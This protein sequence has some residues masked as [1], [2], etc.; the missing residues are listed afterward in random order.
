MAAGELSVEIIGRHGTIDQTKVETNKKPGAQRRGGG[1]TGCAFGTFILL[2]IALALLSV[3]CPSFL[4]NTVS[5]WYGTV[6]Q[7]QH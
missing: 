3:I 2:G 5:P 1:I 4:P 6:I 7:W